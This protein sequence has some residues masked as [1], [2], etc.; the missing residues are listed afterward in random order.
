[1]FN[2]FG[3]YLICFC[4]STLTSMM[5]RVAGTP[6]KPK[7]PTEQTTEA[8]TITTPPNPSV[9]LLSICDRRTSNLSTVKL[10]QTEQSHFTVFSHS[11]TL[12]NSD[13]LLLLKIPPKIILHHL[14]QRFVMWRVNSQSVM[15][16]KKKTN[17]NFGTRWKVMGLKRKNQETKV[18]IYV[19]FY[20]FMNKY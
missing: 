17:L 9:T 1:M 2:K 19:H 13:L 20:Y 8:S 12:Q 15:S 14:H 6:T 10:W 16:Q 7:K 11:K 18:D 5:I 3:I 4:I